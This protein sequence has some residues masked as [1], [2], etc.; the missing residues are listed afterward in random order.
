MQR[1]DTEGRSCVWE[2]AGDIREDGTACGYGVSNYTDKSGTTWSYKGCFIN[3]EFEGKG[4]K[5]D[6]F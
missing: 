1:K 4:K 2:Y 6:K 5:L 3:D